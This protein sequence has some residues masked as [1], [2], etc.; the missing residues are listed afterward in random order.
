MAPPL[1]VQDPAY[2]FPPNSL[3]TFSK[4]ATGSSPC[5]HPDVSLSLLTPKTSPS[6]P[7]LLTPAGPSQA[8]AQLSRVSSASPDAP[9]PELPFSRRPAL[10]NHLGRGPRVA[11]EFA[12]PVA[13]VPP[14]HGQ[15]G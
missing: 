12:D 8:P 2:L 7:L 3:W 10:M 14:S 11:S 6:T 13:S 15:G 1:L 5:S 9:R 4:E